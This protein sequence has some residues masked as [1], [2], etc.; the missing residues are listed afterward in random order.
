MSLRR[1]GRIETSK[2]TEVDD[3]WQGRCSSRR[4]LILEGK[5]HK[6]TGSSLILMR[7]PLFWLQQ[8]GGATL[9]TKHIDHRHVQLGVK[10]CASLVGLVFLSSLSFVLTLR[11]QTFSLKKKLYLLALLYSSFL[12]S[13]F[14]FSF[15]RLALLYQT[16]KLENCCVPDGAAVWPH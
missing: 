12:Q 15:V 10:A 1:G 7:W 5:T 11:R 9:T 6:H 4:A 14:L 3:R 13:F 2:E 16:R 8:Q